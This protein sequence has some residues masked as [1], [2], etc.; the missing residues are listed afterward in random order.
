M[1]KTTFK[2][3]FVLIQPDATNNYENKDNDKAVKIL[4]VHIDEKNSKLI[5]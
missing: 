4:E 1:R 5:N 3:R 2:Y